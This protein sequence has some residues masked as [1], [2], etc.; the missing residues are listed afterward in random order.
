MRELHCNLQIL[1]K[2]E[3][4][5]KL[6]V[7]LFCLLTETEIKHQPCT[8]EAKGEGEPDADQPPIE[9]E[10]EEVA[11]WKGNDEIGNESNVHDGFH[12]GN[13]TEGVGVVTLHPVTELIDNEW[14]DEACHHECHFSIVR[15]PVADF[16]S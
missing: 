5:V 10:A 4:Y 6:K 15:K 3:V 9:D 11:D 16:I 2:N 1:N 13:A 12:I 7:T 14:D 8:G